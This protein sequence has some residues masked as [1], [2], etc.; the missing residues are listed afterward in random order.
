MSEARKWVYI[1]NAIKTVGITLEKNSNPRIIYINP[2]L[3]SML[4]S[5]PK[6]WRKNLL[7]ST[8]T[9]RPQ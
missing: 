7:K 6:L 5:L 9:I 4:K 1:V 3:I 2:K 8:A